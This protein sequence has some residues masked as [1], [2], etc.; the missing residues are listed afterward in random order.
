MALKK[1]YEILKDMALPRWIEDHLP[2]PL[3]CLFIS[4]ERGQFYVSYY[5]KSFA[6]A[7]EA[8]EYAVQFK[9]EFQIVFD[10]SVNGHGGRLDGAHFLGE[11]I[12]AETGK[13][14]E[15]LL[16]ALNT[17]DSL[18][19]LKHSYFVWLTQYSLAYDD[20]PEDFFNAYNFLIHHPVFWIKHDKGRSYR[21][22]TNK[23][24]QF[25]RMNVAR[26]KDNELMMS[27]SHGSHKT[28][29]FTEYRNDPDL[30]SWGRTYEDVVVT[31]A[32]KV[33]EKFD[34]DG[35]ERRNN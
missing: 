4:F 25:A 18:F 2:E 12:H 34:L 24:L 8:Y 3:P 32:E 19:S 33:H 9:T 10:E 16:S 27:L 7:S 14:Y 15:F 6:T 23:G 28:D 1:D 22:V 17:D 29:E 5:T 13:P 31:L 20:D 30:V 11:G 26:K 21:W 35:Y